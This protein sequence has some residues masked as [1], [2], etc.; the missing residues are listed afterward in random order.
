MQVSYSTLL[1]L[2][3]AG[4]SAANVVL[5]AWLREAGIFW[6][7]EFLQVHYR[8]LWGYFVIRISDGRLIIIPTR[9]KRHSVSPP[10]ITDP[11][12]IQ[13]ER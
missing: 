13:K 5:Q 3:E 11:M 10:P 9:W 1:M 6:E 12:R 4:D 7:P 8:P 2:S